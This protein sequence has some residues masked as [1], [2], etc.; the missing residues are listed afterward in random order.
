VA[1]LAQTALA[2][3]S[4]GAELTR[5]LLAFARHQALEPKASDIAALIEQTRRLLQRTL[6]EDI[7][8]E[9]RAVSGLW[10]AVVDGAELE[11]ALLNL[12]INARD[13]MPRGG[14]LSITAG[15]LTLDASAVAAAGLACRPGDYVALSVVDTGTG[16][17][18]E[19]L[20]RALEPFFT[21]K[22]V[23]QGSGLG[24]SM[25]YGFCKQSGG[26]M[27]IDSTL[28][29]GTSVTLFLPRAEGSSEST[30]ATRPIP[31]SEL[32]GGSETI[33]VVEDNAEVR[34]YVVGC[35]SGLGYEVLAAE[36]GPAGLRQLEKR[37]DTAL[38]F[39][40]IVM[41]GGMNGWEVAAAAL[42]LYPQLKVLLTSGYAPDHEHRPAAT[43]AL[44]I[45]PKPYPRA[46][47]AR[48]LRELLDPDGPAPVPAR[49]G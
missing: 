25:V 4:R 43:A 20:R 6:G 10:P 3:A 17:N 11:H 5:R 33:L 34:A 15:N 46:V 36:D 24:L 30:E 22:E 37:P 21:T 44:P 19:V 32:P 42:A 45:L 23:G 40:D 28:G 48:K 47:L 26:D 39:S 29:R 41:P 18:P 13:A 35:L 27:R 49:N 7:G 12:A 16:M 9:T 31:R 1:P 38:M 14:T 8:I 2:A